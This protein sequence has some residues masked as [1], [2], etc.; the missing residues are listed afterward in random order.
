MSERTMLAEHGTK[1]IELKPS[2]VVQAA[3]E[4]IRRHRRNKEAAEDGDLSFEQF[5]FHRK[6]VR[7]AVDALD[8]LVRAYVE[9]GVGLS[10]AKYNT[11]LLYSSE[12][13]LQDAIDLAR[14][15]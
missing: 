3:E 13:L 4:D 1:L 2:T 9:P 15:G 5:A 14:R 6:H 12:Q 11:W 10:S 7:K 8:L